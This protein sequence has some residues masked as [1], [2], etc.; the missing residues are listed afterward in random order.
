MFVVLKINELFFI[1]F[2]NDSKKKYI[3]D[4]KIGRQL[5]A[6]GVEEE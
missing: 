2:L 4:T 5:S 6:G 1:T 3:H